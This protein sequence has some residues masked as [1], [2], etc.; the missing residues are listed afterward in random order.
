MSMKI[1]LAVDGSPASRAA[2]RYVAE[3][4][5]GPAGECELH[6]LYVHFRIPPR[7]A[8]ALGREVLAGYYE[9]ETRKETKAVRALL[10]RSGSVYRFVRK[11]GGA[12]EEIAAYANAGAFNLVVMGSHGYGR[13]QSVLLGSVTQKVL[14]SC[15]APV[16][17]VRP[18]RT[19]GT[20][21]GV[22]AAVDGSAHA[23]RA[24]AY[25]IEHRVRLAPEQTITLL[26]VVYAAPASSRKGRARTELSP[27]QRALSDEAMRDARRLLDKARIPFREIHATGDPGRIIA[28]YA[29]EQRV[30]LLVM[31]SHGRGTLANLV[32]GSVT[33][34]A[35]AGCQVPALI[36]R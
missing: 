25:L 9:S 32:M 29:R 1:L 10:D 30:A 11:L 13:V 15:D 8:H 17:I 18:Q 22:L 16:L 28:A 27:T 20:N 6:M 3:H 35:L 36:V 21:E 7:P 34:K 14:A 12:A 33:Q 23:R 31:G 2:T 24:I 4:F 5:G 19:A 26:H